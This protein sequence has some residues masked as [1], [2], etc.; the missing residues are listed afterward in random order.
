MPLSWTICLTGAEGTLSRT[1]D[2]ESFR[3]ADSPRSVY[4]SAPF[5][6]IIDGE[7]FYIHADLVSS[8]SKP[9]DRMINGHME[10]AQ[11][12]FATLKDVDTGT[13]VRFIEWAYRGYYTA[14]DFTTVEYESP[15]ASSSQSHHEVMPAPQEEYV[16]EVDL[17]TQVVWDVQP[18]EA[19]PDCLPASPTGWE[20]P[21]D[22]SKAQIARGELKEAFISRK[23]TVRQ[24][25]FR[26][27]PPRPNQRPEEDYTNVFLSH[28]QLYVFADMYDIQPLKELS[29]EELRAT[30]AIYTLYPVR[31]GDNISLL[32]YAYKDEGKEDL[33]EM[34]TAYIGYEMDTLINDGD[35]RSLM[36]ED[37][38][39]LF[40]NF[41]TM[42]G[43]RIS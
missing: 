18:P 9:L 27:P 32:R 24:S 17:E 41:M 20:M 36:I 12:G 2:R 8:H 7:P 26:I 29:L 25:V 31:T 40:A 28:A 38:G 34:L 43:I 16:E 15:C 11:K 13:F 19:E 10:E 22:Q 37:G 14:A 5:K 4:T 35:F 21:N 42:V 6:F 23:D 30:L 1:L 3:L 33:R 39:P